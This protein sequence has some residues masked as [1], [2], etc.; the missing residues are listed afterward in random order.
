VDSN[1]NL[2]TGEHAIPALQ[3]WDAHRL[4]L[5]PLVRANTREDKVI[6]EEN[7]WLKNACPG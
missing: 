4:F 5:R 2:G 6:R 3:H 7:G 1:T